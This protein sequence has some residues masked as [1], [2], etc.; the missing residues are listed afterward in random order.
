LTREEAREYIDRQIGAELPKAKK[1]VSGYDTFICPICGNGSGADGTGICTKDG[2]HY[3]CFR[4]C[5]SSVDYLDILKQQHGT[6]TEMDVFSLYGLTVDGGTAS[7]VS[8]AAR[9]PAAHP[10]QPVKKESETADYTQYFKECNARAGQTEYFSFRGIGPETISRF[11]LGYDPA[12]QHPNAPNAPATARVIIPT[13]R[14]SYLARAINPDAPA[15]YQKQKVGAVNLFN[16]KAL[17][18]VEPFVFVVEGEFDALSVIEIGGQ[19][20]GLGSTSN[21]GKLIEAIKAAPP[22]ATLVLSLDNDEPGQK[23]QAEIKKGLEGLGVSF[24]EANIS[25][26]YKDPNDALQNDRECLAGFVKDP[27]KVKRAEQE[28]RKAAYMGKYAVNNCLNAFMGAIADAANTPAIPTGFPALDDALDGGLY[29]GLYIIGAISSIGKT[30]WCLQIA[31][32]IA[33]EGTDV[34]IFSLEM[35]K[36]ELISKSLSRLTIKADRAKNEKGFYYARTNRQI[37][38]GAKYRHYGER[39]KA[40][41]TQAIQTYSAYSQNIY[42]YEGIGD[43]G[44]EQIKETVKEHISIT[45]KR[46]VVIVDYLQI[47]TPLDVRMTDKQATDRSVLALKKM[48]REYKVPVLAVSSFNRDNYTAPVNMASFKESGA[49]EYSSD[50]LFGLQFEGMDK[51]SQAE[52]KKA[53]AIKT[54]DEWKRENPRKVELKILKNRNGATGDS[55][56]FDY[57]A[58]FN[59]FSER[60]GASVKGGTVV[61]LNAQRR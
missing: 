44:A 36:Y 15:Q 31:D 19:A 45:G 34:L 20:V 48:S 56:L 28:T 61:Q 50:V 58:L 4:G 21:A 12:W 35:S 57:Y 22:T 39:E 33:A 49:I 14:G 47:L 55:V 43:I 40:L 9:Q 52:G 27:L 6:E 1:R 42:I 30:T 51:V 13:S 7:D 41:I 60:T 2:K 18:S 46:P 32:Q 29:E 11:M 53:E 5:F 8:G 10:G 23:I 25:G 24:L 38:A 17:Q 59:C 37:T 16:A 3:T 54:V 26:E